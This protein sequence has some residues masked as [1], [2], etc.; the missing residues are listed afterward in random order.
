MPNLVPYLHV[1]TCAR[2]Q[3]WSQ[4]ARALEYAYEVRPPRQLTVDECRALRSAEDDL[5]YVGQLL[6]CLRPTLLLVRRFK[7]QLSP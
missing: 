2:E 6:P 4:A 3:R 5:V 7:E 1:L